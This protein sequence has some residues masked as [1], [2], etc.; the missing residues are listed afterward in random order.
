MN[1]AHDEPQP[2][3]LMPE[4]TPESIPDSRLTERLLARATRSLGVIDVRHAERH[5]S[6]LSD[7]L[8][9]RMPLLEHLRSRYGLTE[10]AG[11]KSL[12]LAFADAG[13][14]AQQ[15]SDES[16]S[17]S[18]AHAASTA[19]AASAPLFTSVAHLPEEPAATMRISRR[20]VPTFS[21]SGAETSTRP[22]H[23]GVEE[24]QPALE[25]NTP[26]LSL[27]PRRPQSAPSAREIPDASALVA[28]AQTPPHTLS[29]PT[30]E[31]ATLQVRETGRT[32]LRAEELSAGGSSTRRAV[33]AKGVGET[34]NP[35]VTRERTRQ[36]AAPPRA[37]SVD[38][39]S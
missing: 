18:V 8:A 30:H 10:Y 3:E 31:R 36:E 28:P 38:E 5:Y 23:A 20:G 26:P 35:K 4:R 2:P 14:H 13:A 16:V 33:E 32:L 12:A 7:W 29:T 27:K 34:A 21:P 24:G 25:D 1:D 19:R 11:A 6:R 22:H 39:T 17:L 9:G 37:S 15:G